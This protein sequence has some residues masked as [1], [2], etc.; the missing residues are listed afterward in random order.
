MSDCTAVTG[1]FFVFHTTLGESR[2]PLRNL[3]VCASGV[4]GSKLVLSLALPSGRAAPPGQAASADVRNSQPPG[5]KTKLSPPFNRVGA[6]RQLAGAPASG[7]IPTMPRAHS[8]KAVRDS[9]WPSAETVWTR[10]CPAT[11]SP[12]SP[13]ARWGRRPGGSKAP[14][15]SQRRTSPKNYPRP[16]LDV[17]ERRRDGQHAGD[18]PLQVT[19]RCQPMCQPAWPVAQLRLAEPHNGGAAAAAPGACCVP[20][21]AQSGCGDR[22]QQSSAME[23]ARSEHRLLPE[24]QLPRRDARDPRGCHRRE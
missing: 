21:P 5:F 7:R 22:S 6:S 9:A 8:P 10:R 23:P 14:G 18:L 1:C 19:L 11:L 13:T 4:F 20:P 16:S 24:R 3:I 15:G 12:A 2:D 17:R